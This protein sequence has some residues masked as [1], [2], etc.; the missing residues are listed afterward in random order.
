MA[1]TSSQEVDSLTE[2]SH[3][4][5][6]RFQCELAVSDD[7]DAPVR[8]LSSLPAD[9]VAVDVRGDDDDDADTARAVNS[10]ITLPD[11]NMDSLNEDETDSEDPLAPV[12]TPYSYRVLPLSTTEILPPSAPVARL[13]AKSAKKCNNKAKTKINKAVAVLAASAAPVVPAPRVRAIKH[14]HAS[15]AALLQR[16]A[17]SRV[18][19][20]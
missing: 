7:K 20:D 11:G 18:M 10:D 16:S 4:P 9:T 19:L 5:A 8:V 6:V 17:P 2:E 1:A 13:S 3:A 15:A 14:V 12:R